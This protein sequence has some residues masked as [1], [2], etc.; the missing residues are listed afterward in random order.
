MSLTSPVSCVSDDFFVL[1]IYFGFT[2]IDII[3]KIR[4]VR[5]WVWRW[6]F[7][8]WVL[9]YVPFSF[10]LWWISWLCLR[11]RWS[12]WRFYWSCQWGRVWRLTPDSNQFNLWS[13]SVDCVHTKSSRF[14][15]WST[16]RNI[17]APKILILPPSFKISF[18][19]IVFFWPLPSHSNCCNFS[20]NVTRRR[21]V[22]SIGL[23]SKS[24]G[25]G[26]EVPEFIQCVYGREPQMHEVRCFGSNVITSEFRPTARV[27]LGTGV[28]GQFSS[29]Y[30]TLNGRRILILG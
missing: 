4:F 15:R 20:K 16:H 19:T 27:D 3:R 1:Y 5:W 8:L 30:L 24:G 7:W 6:W 14:Q 23:T 25:R 29:D 12:C 17:L 11:L 22:G 18:L 9:W 26:T 10:L 13:C 21:P 2:V 28:V